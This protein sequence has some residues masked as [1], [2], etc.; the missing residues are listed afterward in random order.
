LADLVVGASA[1]AKISM[2]GR[3]PVSLSALIASAGGVE[4]WRGQCGLDT[5][6]RTLRG[7]G[8]VEFVER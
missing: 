8:L 3:W 5:V 4:F 6:S 1:T 7:G 2:I